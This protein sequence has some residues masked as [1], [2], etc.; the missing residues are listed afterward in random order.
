V[1][2]VPTTDGKRPLVQE[3]AAGRYVICQGFMSATAGRILSPNRQTARAHDV[4]CGERWHFG[5]MP[6]SKESICPRCQEAA[7]GPR[8]ETKTPCEQP[9]CPGMLSNLTAIAY[10]WR[11]SVHLCAYRHITVLPSRS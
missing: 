1:V 6:V 2:L 9:G 5:Y 3:D 7:A 8:A 10:S 11:G 4:R